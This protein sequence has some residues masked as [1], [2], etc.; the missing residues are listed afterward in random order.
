LSYRNR[1]LAYLVVV[2]LL[3]G[4]GFAAV[5]IAGSSEISGASLT[6]AAF[7]FALYLAALVVARFGVP[8][9]VP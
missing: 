2:G 9:A 5:Y 3:T 8:Y 1:E 7:F 4:I 6:Y